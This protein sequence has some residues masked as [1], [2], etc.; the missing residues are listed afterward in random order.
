MCLAGVPDMMISVKYW[1]FKTD[2]VIFIKK[3]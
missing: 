3:T 2:K 1:E